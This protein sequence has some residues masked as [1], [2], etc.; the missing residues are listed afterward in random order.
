MSAIIWW[1]LSRDVDWDI[2]AASGDKSTFV[3]ARY[4]RKLERACVRY[5]RRGGAFPMRKH[6]QR[7]RDT[8]GLG[9]K[10]D[11]HAVSLAAGWI[12]P[13]GG[14]LKLAFW[15]YRPTCT[16]SSH[17]F[18]ATRWRCTLNIVIVSYQTTHRIFHPCQCIAISLQKHI[19]VLD[20]GRPDQVSI[21]I[22]YL[23]GEGTTTSPYLLCFG[24][25]AD[26]LSIL[27]PFRPISTDKI[28]I[29]PICRYLHSSR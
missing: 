10:L 8:A 16:I 7:A 14:Y 29:G 22:A 27:P 23:P 11:I 13:S 6:P 5:F 25:T 3:I 18:P 4:R 9:T 15:S 17:V 28:A 21:N 20:S 12:G 19:C 26:Q 1:I 24:V 2:G